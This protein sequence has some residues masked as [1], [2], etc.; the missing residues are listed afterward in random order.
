MRDLP[1][2]PSR[3]R[4]LRPRARGLMLALAL[5]PAL[6][7]T[8]GHRCVGSE[9]RNTAIVRV[10]K[11]TRL[12]VVNI[13]GQKMVPTH[14][15]DH[16][17]TDNVRRVNGMGTG[18]VIDERGYIITN[19]HVVDGVR[20]IRVTLANGDTHVATLISH[21]PITDL[22]IIKISIPTKLPVINIGTSAD[23][24][25]G[26]P[27]IAIGNAYGYEH[28]VTE[29]IISSL[30]RTV[31][32]SDT[33]RYEDQIQTSASIN[34]GNSGGPLM[35]IDGEMIGINVAVR[36]GAQS[37][38]F[39]I[40]VDK[41]MAVA[42]DLMS[43][44]RIDRA[45]HGVVSKQA[46]ST[47]DP[48]VVE[49]VEADSPAASGG[50]KPGDEITVVGNT[51]IERALDIERALLGRERDEEVEFK[52]QRGTKSVTLSIVLASVPSPRNPHSKINK[53]AWD[54]IGLRLRPIPTNQFRAPEPRYKGGLA[55]TE[56]RPGSTASNQGIRRGD[57][58]LGVHRW[59][60]ISMDN[61]SY[62]LSIADLPVREPVKFWVLRGRQVFEG[63]LRLAARPS[64]GVAQ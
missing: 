50:L 61:V 42:A 23:L 62:I 48:V 20:R 22:A 46:S 52:V 33:Q 32:V 27:A 18:V 16:S 5:C 53:L 8:V 40:P 13:H 21:E 6:L 55:I 63:D 60:T 31:H 29:G 11:N 17:R 25:E 3:P 47:N 30:H 59:E 56:V 57:I 24:K 26:E 14:R 38:A 12:S 1:A 49:S 19:Y 39:A 2:L 28:T 45:W 43:V 44:R 64:T 51:K 15:N 35:N 9:L 7:F 58:L 34:P 36:A 10:V 54:A 37:I 41:A 4:I